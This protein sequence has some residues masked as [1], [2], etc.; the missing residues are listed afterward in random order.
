M[1]D[2]PAAVPPP[3]GAPEPERDGSTG[4]VAHDRPEVLVG[5]AFVGAF[6]FAR[7]LKRITS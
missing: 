3:P 7:I 5:G 2:S 6:L 1:A 4:D